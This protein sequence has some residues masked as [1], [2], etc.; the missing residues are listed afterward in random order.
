[1]PG[2]EPMVYQWN[3]HAFG[4]TSSPFCANY[5]LL[6]TFKDNI[7]RFQPAL[8]ASLIRQFYVDYFLGSVRSVNEARDIAS[9]LSELLKCG[10]F[11]L[12]K[13]T[14][15]ANEVIQIIKPDDRSPNAREL[16]PG[17]S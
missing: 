4:A 15:N 3:V 5:A 17:E 1:M 2:G 16:M 11:D 6:R 10:G 9:G 8:D 12:V 7:A 14:S 13:W